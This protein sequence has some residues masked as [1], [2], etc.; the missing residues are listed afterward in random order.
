MD[1]KPI[2]IL[3][4]DNDE[5]ILE[6]MKVLLSEIYDL[7]I[8]EDGLKA[9]E[10]INTFTPQ[11]MFIDLIM[12][13]IGG[14]KLCQILRKNPAF[15]KVPLVVLSAI[16]PEEETDFS[17]YGFDSCIAKGPLKKVGESVIEIIEDFRSTGRS[18]VGYRTYGLENLYK[19]EITKELL[20]TKRHSD[21]ILGNLSECILE[22]TEEGYIVFSNKAAISLLDIPEEKLLAAHITDIFEEESKA[23]IEGLY[24]KIKSRNRQ[25]ITLKTPIHIKEKRAIAAMLR[26]EEENAVTIIVIMNDVTEKV[27]AEEKLKRVN[28]NL[29]KRVKERTEELEILLSEIHHRVKNNLQIILSI[30]SVQ[31]RGSGNSEFIDLSKDLRNRITA[32]SLIHEKLYMSENFGNINFRKYAESIAFHLIQSFGMTD[33]YIDIDLNI[34]NIFVKLDTAIPCGIIINELISNSLK[35]AFSDQQKG[36]IYIEFEDLANDRFKLTVSDSGP[37]FPEDFNLEKTETTGMKIVG[38]LVRQLR[39]SMV[40]T[41]TPRHG[42]SIEFKL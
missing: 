13:N 41:D 12:P 24:K 42:I 22:L 16:S 27:K 26:V 3:V 6:F 11:I 32:I 17:L 10:V 20:S 23:V 19:R 25:T 36:S 5:T 31:A 4:V 40:I 7:R 28:E 30:L 21:L 15:E 34:S 29:E 2:Q 18:G 9:L 39:G 37:G 33:R 35:H 8:A 1:N 14:I 38:T